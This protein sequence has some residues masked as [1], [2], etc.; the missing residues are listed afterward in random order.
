MPGQV[1]PIPQGYHTATPYLVVNDAAK[2]IEFYKRAFD[3]KEKFRMEGP[4]GKIGHAELQ[5]GDSI[6]MLAD[7][8]PQM[9][10]KA[11][12]SLGGTTAGIFL[13]V[14]D[15]DAAFN[16]AVG[17]GAKVTMPVADMFWGD[18]YGKLMDPFG[19]SW[20]MA[21]HKEDVAPE[22][23]KRRVQAEMTARQSGQKTRTAG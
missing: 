22:E 17:A 9:D 5:I 15:V 3:A 20:S 12:Q 18:R 8:M 11:P 2:A 6:F 4:P 19:H 14:K 1:Q 13:Y 7:E 10:A 23:M 21:T 16:K